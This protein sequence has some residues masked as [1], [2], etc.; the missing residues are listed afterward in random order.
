MATI[1]NNLALDDFKSTDD[2]GLPIEPLADVLLDD[3]AV[4]LQFA[5]DCKMHT[6][7]LAVFESLLSK[8]MNDRKYFASATEEYVQNFFPGR[9]VK[10][11]E[12]D[13]SHVDVFVNGEDG[14][15]ATCLVYYFGLG[16]DYNDPKFDLTQFDNNC[17]I[18]FQYFLKNGQIDWESLCENVIQDF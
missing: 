9:K 16:G 11:D 13:L 10:A 2:D 8:W 3:A 14:D 6:K 17:T 7:H 1:W 15:N 5:G 4:S 12:L 18:E